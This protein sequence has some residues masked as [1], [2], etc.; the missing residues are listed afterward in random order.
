MRIEEF[1]DRQRL[2]LLIDGVIDYAVYILDLEGHVVSWNSGAERLKGYKADEIIGQPY[3]KFFTSDDQTRGLPFQALEIAK[4]EGR[5]ETEGWRVRK[6]GTRFWAL[7]VVDPIR[8][9]TGSVIGFAKITRDI[10]ERRN[11]HENLLES[12]RKFRHLVQSILDYA[13]YQLDPDGL[14]AT[15]NAGAERIK[16]YRAEEIIGRHFS[17]FYTE[18]ERAAGVPAKALA[19]AAQTGKYETEGWRVRKDGTRFWALVVIDAIRI[20]DELIGF[21]K[22]TRDITDRLQ[23]QRELQEIQAQLAASQR[24]ESI[25]QLTGGIAHDFNNLLMIVLGNLET[26]ERNAKNVTGTAVTNLQRSIAN[27]MR[28]AQRAATLTQRLLA[29][30][31]RQALDPK[32]LDIHKFISQMTDFLQR[33]LGETI[34]VEAVGSAGLWQVEVDPAQLETSIVNLAINARDAMPEGGKL[35]IEA[36]NAYLDSAYARRNPEVVPGQYVLICVTD[37]GVGMTE[38]ILSQAFEPFFTTK[39]IG[40]G[41]GLGLSQVYGF[42]KQSRGHLKIY[43]E[44]GQ[45]T[46]IKMYFPRL[47][48]EERASDTEL[49]ATS[50][51][52]TGEIGETIMVVEDNVELRA[53]LMETLRDLDYRVIGAPDAVTALDAL[54]D[55]KIRVDLMLTD[56]VMKGMNGDDLAQRARQLRPALKI[57]F[58]TGYSRNAFAHQRRIDKEAELLQKPISQIDLATRVRDALDKESQGDNPR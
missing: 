32:P 41:T 27:A 3:A 22:V 23:A 7:A 33:T 53:Y 58:M 36:L 49:E 17:Q 4:T 35:T 6:D 57:L 5:F 15:W 50:A 30:S 40:H 18:E 28:G 25:G 8:D 19:T 39:E 24:M 48:S 37:T 26:A 46:T 34:D 12:E 20:N 56:V 14:V 21:A 1:D 13:V 10:T 54:Q 44:P 52:G 11:T 51:L 55:S 47:Y 38:D 45:G 31:R 2:Q 42:V 43:S 16:G 29:F 9:E